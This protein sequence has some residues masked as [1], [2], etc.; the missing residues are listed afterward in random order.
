METAKIFW[1]GRSQAVRLPR[2]FRVDGREVRIRRR[3]RAIVLEPVPESWEWLDALV[4]EV[5]DDLVSAA[6][7][8][9]EATERPELDK[10]F[11]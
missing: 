2:A 8:Q 10:V 1:S 3:G 6:R 9:P 11:R 7:E 5:D 4:D